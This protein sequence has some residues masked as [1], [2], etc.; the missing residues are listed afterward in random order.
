MNYFFLFLSSEQVF[1]GSKGW[2]VETDPVNPLNVYGETKAEAER[3]VLQN[4]QHGAI[5]LE[6]DR[7]CRRTSGRR[8]TPW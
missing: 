8:S 5:S 1:D 4:P 7:E 2:Y 6:D 3:L